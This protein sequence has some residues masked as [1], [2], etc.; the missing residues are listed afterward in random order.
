MIESFLNTWRG[1]GAR[2][3]RMV[4]LAG[5]VV[6]A[7]LV[8]LVLFEP[9]WQAR[10]KLAQELPQLQSQ[11]AQVKGLGAQ[12]RSLK[13]APAVTDSPSVLKTQIEDSLSAVSLRSTLKQINATSDTIELRFADAPFAQW[14]PWLEAALR[15]TR[16]RVVDA[17]ITRDAGLGLVSARLVL[18]VPRAE[19][20]R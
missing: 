11:L 18:E 15:E 8:Y 6:I 1:L 2:E 20:S 10:K 14:W 13:A 7:A 3:R 17:S 5:A 16:L 19:A 9:A 4:G 12:A